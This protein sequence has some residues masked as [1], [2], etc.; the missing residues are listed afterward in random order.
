MVP[1]VFVVGGFRVVW[2]QAASA[3]T[4]ARL[5][6]KTP[7]PHHATLNTAGRPHVSNPGSDFTHAPQSAKAP[8]PQPANA[9]VA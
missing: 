2:Y 4:V 5:W 7:W 1:G 6:A 3:L 8:R 9:A